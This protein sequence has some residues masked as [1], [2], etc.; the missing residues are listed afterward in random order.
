M[1]NVVGKK[2]FESNNK[3]IALNILYVPHNT[4]EIRHAYKSKHYLNRE[5]QVILL[6]ITHGKKMAL[7][8]CKK[9]SALL[10]R[11]TSNNNEGFHCLNCFCSYSTENKLKKHKNV[12]ENNDYC[13]VEIP[14]E[15]SKILK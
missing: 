10:R 7:S 15:D 9:L 5:N 2:N 1:I 4:K 8:C 14:K 11:I 12:C 13:C 6:M 3:S